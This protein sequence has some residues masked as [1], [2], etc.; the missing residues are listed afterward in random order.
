MALMANNNHDKN[1]YMW[2]DG[3]RASAGVAW[4]KNNLSGP[5]RDPPLDQ[6]SQIIFGIPKLVWSVH[7]PACT[8]K[9]DPPGCVWTR[10]QQ[11]LSCALR[12]PVND[13][14]RG[15]HFHHISSSDFTAFGVKK[16][17][18]NCETNHP[19]SNR[20]TTTYAC[21]HRGLWGVLNLNSPA[22]GVK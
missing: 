10:Y 17:P 15:G 12:F 13:A 18:W 20:R 16:Q 7:S 9:E 4:H 21:L 8:N 14:A 6:T 3:G 22:W 5:A 1:P 11:T 2:R 19:R